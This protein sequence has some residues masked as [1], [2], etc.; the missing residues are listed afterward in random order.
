VVCVCGRGKDPPVGRWVTLPRVSVAWLPRGWWI[1][2]LGFG[3]RGLGVSV[4][5]GWEVF[6]FL[7]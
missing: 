1:E 5:A 2:A 4:R 6:L 3:V 7:G